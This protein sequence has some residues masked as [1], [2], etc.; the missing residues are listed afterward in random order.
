MKILRQNSLIRTII[1]PN[2][3]YSIHLLFCF[4]P[5]EVEVEFISLVSSLGNV[6]RGQLVFQRV[7]ILNGFHYDIFFILNGHYSE[8]LYSEG[9]LF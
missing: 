5:V 4:V 8:K 9:L 6:L 7:L 1:R 2:N 3:E